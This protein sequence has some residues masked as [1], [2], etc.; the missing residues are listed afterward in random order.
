[1]AH[2]VEFSIA[3]LAG[4]EGVYEKRLRGG[5]NVFF[6]PNGSGKTSM[7]KILHSAMIGDTSGLERVPFS[8]ARVT[9]YLERYQ[10][11]FSRSVKKPRELQQLEWGGMRE[12]EEEVYW[13]GG[14][15][16]RGDAR[17]ERPSLP[18]WD[19]SPK[20]PERPATVW[21]IHRYLPISRLY[22]PDVRAGRFMELAGGRPQWATEHA[23]DVFFAQLVEN[24]WL[25]YSSEV[26][27]Q[28]REAQEE[29]LASILRAVL[30]APPGKRRKRRRT[31]S[32]DPDQAY[33][34]IHSFLERRG[35]ARLL[36]SASRF[37]SRYRDDPA[38]Q[39]V[40]G[41]IDTVEGTI[42][43]AMAPR[44]ELQSL[45]Q[46]MFAGEKRVSFSDRSID[47]ESKE[48]R[49]IG[50]VSLSSGEKHLLL[51]LVEALLAEHN[52]IL[53]DEP[54]MSLHVDW[55]R[56]LLNAMR[57]LNPDT[58]VIVA[59]HSPEIMADVPDSRIFRI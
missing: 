49:R 32:L 17:S 42:E 35:S 31:R 46:G 59:T 10:K 54:E 3:G 36:G 18:S 29:G 47:V 50:L 8:E 55:Q 41:D 26:L 40:V 56:S 16:H 27:T 53:I 39:D 6:G 48:G 4:R 51:I 7:L 13:R 24:L 19:T 38:L 14:V 9:V 1:M 21:W 28:V 11:E 12:A 34:V 52:T 58:Q 22:S 23:I 37:K 5:V 45:I 57:T 2:I 44:N 15:M 43:R 25:E 33:E 20:K 30:S